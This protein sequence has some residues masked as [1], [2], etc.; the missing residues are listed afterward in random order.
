V[1]AP[2]NEWSEVPGGALTDAAVSAVVSGDSIYLF[3]KGIDVQRIYF[4]ATT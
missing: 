3:G 2:R 1:T 4:N